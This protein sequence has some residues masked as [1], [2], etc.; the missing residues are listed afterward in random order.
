MELIIP[1]EKLLQRRKRRS[2]FLNKV[3]GHFHQ[4]DV[5]V[6]DDS[7]QTKAANGGVEQFS[8]FLPLQF[9]EPVSDRHS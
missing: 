7:G 9:R 1:F 8:I 2:G 6:G 4:L 3:R 5:G